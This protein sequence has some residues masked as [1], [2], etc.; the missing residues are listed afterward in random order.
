M[1]CVKNYNIIKEGDVYNDPAELTT[2]VQSS[3]IFGLY[4]GRFD[5]VAYTLS[6]GEKS[7]LVIEF[8][9]YY[10]ICNLKYYVSPVVLSDVSVSYGLDS[11]T[12][13][14]CSI[15]SS[16][17]FIFSPIDDYV[18]FVRITH[19]GSIGQDVYQIFIEP[20]EAGSFGFGT[21]SGVEDFVFYDDTPVGYDSST[22]LEL[23][24]YND[25]DKPRDMY[26]SVA[27]TLSGVDNYIELSTSYDGPFYKRSEHG[28]SQP[29][30]VP[31]T[32]SGHNLDVSSIEELYNDWDLHTATQ[33]YVE[34]NDGFIRFYVDDEYVQGYRF[35]SEYNWYQG[36]FFISADRF[37]CDQSFTI[38]VEIRVVEAELDKYSEGSAYY[39]PNK[40][41][42][43][44]S[45]SFPLVN[46]GPPTSDDFNARF[47]RFG[48][49]LSAVWLGSMYDT[50]DVGDLCVGSAYND[51][52]YDSFS[53][54]FHRF[55]TCY[56]QN[57][58]N[59]AVRLE[60]LSEEI[61]RE[62]S[63]KDS[64]TDAPW[65]KVYISFDHKLNKVSYYIDNILIDENFF[66]SASLYSACKFFFGFMG[67]GDITFDLRNLEIDR[68]RVYSICAPEA[69]ASAVSSVDSSHTPDKMADSIYGVPYYENSWV[70]GYQPVV[71]D[72]FTLSFSSPQDLQAARI[73]HP[74][75]SDNIVI[76]GSLYKTARY[77][78]EQAVC[79]FDTGDVRY[80]YFDR[81]SV[82]GLNGWNVSYFTTSSGTVEPVRGVTSVS[83]VIAS[84]GDSGSGLDVFCVEEVEL[85]SVSGTSPYSGQVALDKSYPWSRGYFNNADSVGGDSY[86]SVQ[87]NDLYD[88]AYKEGCYILQEGVDYGASSLVYSPYDYEPRHYGE[89]LFKVFKTDAYS[90][91]NLYTSDKKAYI[92]RVFD[93][94]APVKAFLFSFS[95][96]PATGDFYKG[97]V[98]KWKAQYLVERGNPQ[99]DS[100]WVDIP[101]ISVAASS[102]ST[103]ASYTQY[104]VDH[105]DGEYYTDYINSRD[106]IGTVYLP[107]DSFAYINKYNHFDNL[108]PFTG[109]LC[110]T[111]VEFDSAVYT[112]GLRL[113]IE[114]GYLDSSRTQAA[115][116]Y[117]LVYFMAYS[118]YPAGVYVSPVFDT[119]AGLNSEKVW[120]DYD[121]NGGEVSVLYRSSDKKPVGRFSSS[122][123]MWEDVG[124]P[125]YNFAAFNSAASTVSYEDRYLYVF[126]PGID[127]AVVYDTSTRKWSNG[128]DLPREVSGEVIRPDFR[129]RNNTVLVG[130]TII[131]ACYSDGGSGVYSSGIMKYNIKEN[132]YDYSGWELFP[133]QR[134]PE[135]VDAALVSDGSSRVFFLSDDGDITVLDLTTGGLDTENRN[136]VPKHGSTYREYYI[137]AYHSGKIYVA[138]GSGNSSNKLDIYDISSDEWHSG[139]DMPY[140][141]DYSWCIIKDGSLYVCPY[142][143]SSE[144]TAFLKFDLSGSVWHVVNSLGYNYQTPNIIGSKY[145][146]PGNWPVPDVYCLCGDY[147]YLFMVRY[148]GDDVDVR[149]AL[150]V[151]PSWESGYLPSIYD[152]AWS[153]G[154]S[155]GWNKITASGELMPQDRYVQYKAELVSYSGTAQAPVVKGSCLAEPFLLEAVP[156]SGTSNF[157]VRTGVETDR[158]YWCWYAGYDCSEE[159]SIIQASSFSSREKFYNPVSVLSTITSSG[160]T[161][162]GY[163]GAGAVR[164]GD[165]TDI[166]LDHSELLANYEFTHSNIHYAQKEDTG[167]SAP[168]HSIGRNI[169]G[170]YD[171]KGVYGLSAVKD[172]DYYGW[173]TAVDSNGVHRIMSATSTDGLVWSDIT[174]SQNIQTFSLEPDADFSGAKNPSV[175]KR[176]GLYYMW[177][178]GIDTNDVSS[179][180]YCRSNDRNSWFGHE[181]VISVAGLDVNGA[182]GCGNPSV[183][184]DIDTYYIWF[185]VYASGG[186]IIY[187]AKSAGG[188]V[189]SDFVPV[190]AKS[191]EGVHDYNSITDISVIS[192]RDYVESNVLKYGQLK[193]YNGDYS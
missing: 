71:G 54:E 29:S 9:D 24:I 119:G 162:Y 42:L 61:F 141:V 165:T 167:I 158:D 150:V 144:Y 41:M 149:K 160:S 174:L 148:G 95:S 27:P 60:Y 55:K 28:L 14:Q 189:W 92:W 188:V 137:P 168:V 93:S 26:V 72:H 75:S 185:L 153:S 163:T 193:V 16:G 91:A 67:L 131:M 136:K 2:A 113:V 108:S 40:F 45:N 66:S 154:S 143:P 184:F 123:E 115:D 65:R 62:S 180:I 138:G 164:C 64:T 118:Q 18:G 166:W 176:E 58:I 73:R 191:F 104:L 97:K 32:T 94:I 116:G 190:F 44:F 121:V 109:V 173:Y 49:S 20:K 76:S 57:S 161:S 33:M 151:S 110:D 68:G 12:E 157:Y 127:Y 177:Y 133:Y 89:T 132:A 129:T 126:S 1:V 15:T 51:N 82:E 170:T 172:T 46:F 59:H 128:T 152:E 69:V 85:Y 22:P 135:A 105:N 122:Y 30:H 34:P 178:E 98:D 77:H 186:N 78:I 99:V 140:S 87:H 86:F 52:D 39:N 120:L 88:V 117:T 106:G 47:D 187:T 74:S 124:V 70:S 171:T 21:S 31:I 84:L 35:V 101:P 111:Y 130:D 13:N 6:A 142:Y 179:I 36:S 156:A 112:Q 43:G 192:M 183:I 96:N 103:Y 56:N 146:P 50:G 4:D 5:S 53:S 80:I 147:I 81:P 25:S 48:R 90:E 181:Q 175:I 23:S 169:E 7:S 3:G 182:Y 134:Q 79:Y 100:D 83:G 159:S 17:S 19:S 38:S 37:T 155:L 8:G 139:P 102:P 63:Y 107:E 114:D 125:W 10:D 11:S 145:R